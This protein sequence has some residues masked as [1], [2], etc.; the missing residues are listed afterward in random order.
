MKLPLLVGLLALAAGL[1]A[2]DRIPAG[3]ILPVRWNGSISSANSKPGQVITAR[4][5][6]D[7]PL[8][9]GRK[10]RAGSK[11][12]GHVLDV[13]PAKNGTPGKISFQFDKLVRSGETI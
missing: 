6:Q 1:N 12:V 13:T 2:Q 3:T 9:S 11:V 5:M 4:I 7:V 8:G 10:I